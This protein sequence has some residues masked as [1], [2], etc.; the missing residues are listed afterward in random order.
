MDLNEVGCQV[1]DQ[2]GSGQGPVVGVSEH[3][4]EQLVS[5]MS[6]NVLTTEV[7]VTCAV[8]ILLLGVT[9]I[10]ARLL[11]IQRPKFGSWSQFSNYWQ[12]VQNG[13]TILE[14]EGKGWGE[15]YKKKQETDFSK[16][17]KRPPWSKYVQAELCA[18]VLHPI[19]F[20]NDQFR[21]TWNDVV[22]LS[23][24]ALHFHSQISGSVLKSVLSVTTVFKGTY[25]P[26]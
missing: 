22:Y 20:E 16:F 21:D 12:I 4:A 11:K 18:C 25:I 24:L 13:V 6:E 8:W 26:P 17:I 7:T 3:N 1:E 15:E 19:F 5:K 2:T 14:T 23:S 10:P 9:S